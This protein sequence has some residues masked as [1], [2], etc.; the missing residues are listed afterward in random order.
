MI[1]LC[2]EW[3]CPLGQGRC[4]RDNTVVNDL[5]MEVSIQI[6]KILISVIYIYVGPTRIM[7]VIIFFEIK[8]AMS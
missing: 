3:N 4:R 2:K 7:F 5:G 6:M 1:L 8:Q